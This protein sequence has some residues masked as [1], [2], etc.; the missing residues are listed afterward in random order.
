MG[1]IR[2][3][4]GRLACCGNAATGYASSLYKGHRTTAYLSIGEAFT[5]EKDNTRTIVTQI[6]TSAFKVHSYKIAT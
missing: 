2:N 3:C 1:E 5:V 4:L 6:T